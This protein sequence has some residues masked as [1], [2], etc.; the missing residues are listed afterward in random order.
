MLRDLALGSL[1]EGAPPAL[2]V[3]QSLNRVLTAK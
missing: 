1:Q 2:G 3:V